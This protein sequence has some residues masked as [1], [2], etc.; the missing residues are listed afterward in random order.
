MGSR[1]KGS[2]Q[3][4]S[5]RRVTRAMRIDPPPVT[6]EELALAAESRGLQLETS[7]FGPLFKVTARRISSTGSSTSSVFDAGD[8]QDTDII[9]EHDGF[10]APPPFGILHMDS[11]RIY[12][13]RIDKTNESSMRSVF[14]VSILLGATSALMAY[15]K[16]CHKMELLA[17]D[18]GNEYAAKLVKYYSRLGFKEIRKVG[19]GAN[20]D[21]FDLL[22]WGGVG[23]RM[24]GDLE[25]LLTK[26]GGLVRKQA[27]SFKEDN[28]K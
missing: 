9:G 20:T 10:I 22:V 28:N 12:N 17:I 19:D 2:S 25:Q 21:L 8:N 7:T 4:R 16:N 11:M 18:D 5:A 1:A 14:G 23:T 6:K 24:N 27:K 13:S 15:E 26:W 3:T